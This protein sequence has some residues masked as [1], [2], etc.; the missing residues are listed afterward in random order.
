MRTTSILTLSCALFFG[1]GTPTERS[2]G[3]GTN[4]TTGAGRYRLSLLTGRNEVLGYKGSVDLGFKA[5]TSGKS[6]TT[7]AGIQATTGHTRIAPHLGTTARDFELF[8]AADYTETPAYFLARFVV[9][10]ADNEAFL[11]GNS[12]DVSC[13]LSWDDGNKSWDSEDTS[14]S[15]TK[16][17]D[18]YVLTIRSGSIKDEDENRLEV[19]G[20]VTYGPSPSQVTSFTPSGRCSF[21]ELCLVPSVDP[22]EEA[23]KG[24]CFPNSN[25]A[26]NVAACVNN[27][28]DS[29]EPVGVQRSGQSA[30]LC[31]EVCGTVAESGESAPTCDPAYGCIDGR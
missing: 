12:I 17:V 9:D 23:D 7:P 27:R 24:F 11:M 4:T 20:V 18:G 6:G 19:S 3:T 10:F 16:Q 14:C 26:E 2:N 30:C 28:C 13:T 25:L 8:I 1:C 5:P 29:G 31:L 21:D 15:V 22:A